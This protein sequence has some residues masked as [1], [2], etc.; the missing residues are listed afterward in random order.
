MPNT[1]SL[2]TRITWE[3]SGKTQPGFRECRGCRNEKLY[4]V[5]DVCGDCYAQGRGSSPQGAGDGGDEEMSKKGERR[6]CPWC[7]EPKSNLWEHKQRCP[8]RHGVEPK[9]G[10]EMERRSQVKGRTG[11]RPRRGPSH[12]R[13]PGHGR[14][15][16]RSPGC[17]LCAGKHTALAQ[18]LMVRMIRGGMSFAS[19]AETARDVLRMIV[20]EKGGDRG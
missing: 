12:P 13:L 18:D 20:E 1:L 9:E 2:A 4:F 6:E 7:R 19:A 8:K 16:D 15:G 11:R 14:Q 3:A 10:Q 5:G 17:L